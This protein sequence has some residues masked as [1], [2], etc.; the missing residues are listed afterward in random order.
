M[1]GCVAGRVH[2]LRGMGDFA[3][4]RFTESAS[5]SSFCSARS[6]V[7]WLTTRAVGLTMAGQN[8]RLG[9]AARSHRVCSGLPRGMVGVRMGAHDHA[10]IAARAR[11][12]AFPDGR[13]GRAG[14]DGDEAGAGSPTR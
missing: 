2:H 10:D 5:S 12:P 14:V 13:V 8:G 9:P 4:Q 1:V 11:Q 6:G 3:F 7:N